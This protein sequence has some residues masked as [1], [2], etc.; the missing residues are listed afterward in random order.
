VPER[1][2]QAHPGRAPGREEAKQYPD[3]RD[4]IKG[5][6]PFNYCRLAL[7]DRVFYRPVRRS[8]GIVPSP[9]RSSARS[10]TVSLNQAP[11]SR[12]RDGIAN[13]RDPPGALGIQQNAERA[14]HRDARTMGDPAAGK[15]V[16]DS[17][18]A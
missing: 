5:V 7:A 8:R 4:G 9:A 14:G 18:A 13:R 12:I 3:P 6:E 1:I 15:V 16:Q 11:C 2:D 17:W 10:A